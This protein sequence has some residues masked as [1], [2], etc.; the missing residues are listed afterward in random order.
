MK[1]SAVFFL[2]IF[3]GL[4]AAAAL[5]AEDL[6]I[7]MLGGII[8]GGSTSGNTAAAAAASVD[9]RPCSTGLYGVPACC[10]INVAGIASLPCSDSPGNPTTSSAYRAGCASVG[11]EAVCCVLRLDNIAGVLCNK[12]Q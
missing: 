9:V 1:V 10:E 7:P 2:P 8:G 6:L 4:A 5:P 3:A 12:M 11:R